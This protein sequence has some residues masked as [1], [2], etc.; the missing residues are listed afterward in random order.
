MKFE[1]TFS[2]P[3]GFQIKALDPGRW[4]GSPLVDTFQVDAVPQ[5]VH[6]DRLAVA[7][8]LLF[9]QFCGG[10]IAFPNPVNIVTASAIQDYSK[11]ARV[12]IPDIDEGPKPIP[13]G[14]STLNISSGPQWALHPSAYGQHE[15]GLHVL[16]RSE[17]IGSLTSIREVVMASNSILHSC[18]CCG[19]LSG[20]LAAGVI[21]AQDFGAS[22][23]KLSDLQFSSTHLERIENLLISVGLHIVGSE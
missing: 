17:F 13:G 6:P 3:D 1:T 4:D 16:P 10:V 22:N 8:T 19:G 5:T 15:S 2:V 9:G 18:A 14:G 7:I 11:P 21:F 12:F 20:A 23:L